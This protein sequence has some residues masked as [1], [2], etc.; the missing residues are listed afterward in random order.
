[1]PELPEVAH[2]LERNFEGYVATA[3]LFVYTFIIGYTIFQ[4]LTFQNPPSYTLQATL[5]L[6]TWMT[7][8]SAGWALRY[9]SH[10][11]FS[12]VRQNLSERVNY[13]LRY[14]DV[15]LWIL[16]AGIVFYFSLDVLQTRM[17]SGRLIL[18][19]P[20]PLWLA[21]LALP[22]GMVGI[23]VRATQQIVRIRR[24]YRN[25]EDV[26]PTSDIRK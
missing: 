4:R 24:A 10:F 15:G 12:L 17:E 26:T 23:G 6:F 14:V 7:W 5:S 22:V 8:L 16:V 2:R 21:Y 9:D 1:M 20:V 18:G 13:A 11:R 3:V 19:T 25:G